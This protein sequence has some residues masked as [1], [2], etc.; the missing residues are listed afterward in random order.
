MMP[1][2]YPFDAP[3]KIWYV[4]NLKDF[5]YS[6]RNLFGCSMIRA[7]PVF[8]QFFNSIKGLLV[9]WGGLIMCNFAD[10]FIW[11]ADT[12]HKQPTLKTWI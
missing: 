4:I 10:V 2:V 6:I 3:K 9:F 11:A 1:K 8:I 7:R 12:K 5:N